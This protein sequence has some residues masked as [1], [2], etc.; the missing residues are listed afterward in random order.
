MSLRRVTVALGGS[1]YMA[2]AM[3]EACDIAKRNGA[4]L[5]GLAVMDLT[6]VDPVQAAPI[7]GGAAAAELREQREAMVRAGM[8]D[9]IAE[10]TKVCEAAGLPF[11]VIEAEGD[12]QEAITDAMKLSDLGIVGIRHAFDYGT[13]SHDDAF[14]ARVARA[15]NRP[16]IAMTT[17]ARAIRRILV[18]YDGSQVSADALRSFGVLNAFDP[19]VVRVVSCIEGSDTDATDRQLADARGYLELHGYTVETVALDGHPSTAI[20][21]HA[22]A[23]EADVVVMGAV[24]RRGLSK[25]LAGDTASSMLAASDIPLFLRR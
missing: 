10:F 6:L 25:L 5:V 3:A 21:E 23:F 22:R 24:G 11:R 7:G 8:R 13:V 14:L 19:Q 4:E 12:A 9:A 18:A 15:S 20:L 17:P 2:P 16:I 1:E